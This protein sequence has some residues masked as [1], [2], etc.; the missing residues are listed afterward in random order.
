MSHHP[1]PRRPTR[2]ILHRALTILAALQE[3]DFARGDLIARVTAE[4]GESA[5]G[6]SPE[7]AF[8]RDVAWLRELG[9]DVARKADDGCYHLEVGRHPL[10]RFKLSPDELY[11]LSL[12]RRAFER[13]PYADDVTSLVNHIAQYLPQNQQ[14]QARAAP[15]TILVSMLDEI[16][17]HRLVLQ[18]VQEAI[19][20]RRQ[21]EFEYRART[22]DRP[23]RH[24]VTVYDSLELREGHVYFQAHSD[25]S[26]SDLEFRLDRVVPGSAQLLPAKA[27][28]TDKLHRPLKLRYRLS[29]EFASQGA[30]RRFRNHQEERQ[31]D[32]SLV[33]TAEIDESELFWASKTL[34]KYGANCVALEP[35]ELVAEMKR[36]VEQMALNYREVEP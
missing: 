6:Q 7:D 27:V 12:L 22:S 20:Q 9:F 2:E 24:T 4:L 25:R 28:S 30:T 23:K 19:R 35:P 17:P 29:R 31:A 8:L 32:G 18:K 21:L 26:D 3:G 10:L 5:Y 16:G 36:V 15:M 1:R 11:A 33:V 13:T 14:D 34:L